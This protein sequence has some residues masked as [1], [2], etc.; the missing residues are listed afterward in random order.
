MLASNIMKAEPMVA[1][2][3]CAYNHESYIRDALEGFVNQKVKF[4]I[5]AIVHDDASSDSTA[6][7]IREYHS[8]F[9]QII[10]PIFEKENQYSKPGK[11]LRKIME[12]A[13]IKTCAKYVAYCEGDDYW[14]DPLKLQKQV[15]FLESHPEYSMCVTNATAIKQFG[16]RVILPF[17]LGDCDCDISMKDL[18]VKGGGCCSTNTL[19]IRMDKYKEYVAKDLQFHVGDYPMQMYMGHVGKVRFLSDNTAVYRFEHPGS[20]TGKDLKKNLK[21]KEEIA[22]KTCQLLLKM[23]EV[24]SFAYSDIIVSYVNRLM[25]D[26]FYQ[27]KKYTKARKYWKRLDNPIQSL[28]WGIAFD[29]YG[30]SWIHKIV[31]ICRAKI[32]SK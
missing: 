23:D 8:R 15:D 20:W 4:S 10:Y 18:I 26:F 2:H 14:T 32:S 17:N 7:I 25:Y 27:N 22:K 30:F 5:I 3:C 9:P 1:I 13:I 12:N 29:V 19:L 6:E 11:P 24:M 31:G 28:G 16:E 21:E